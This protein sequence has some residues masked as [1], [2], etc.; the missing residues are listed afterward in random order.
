MLVW[1]PPRGRCPVFEVNDAVVHPAHGVGVIR[2]I[3]NMFISGRE[4]RY[5]VIEFPL[6]EIDRVLVPVDNADNVGLRAVVNEETIHEVL[7]ILTDTEGSYLRVV[8]DESF[9]KRHKEYVD[10]VQSG[11]IIEVAQVFKTLL[12]RS[13]DKDLGLK[14]KFLMERAEKM[15]LGEIAFARKI[16]LDNAREILISSKF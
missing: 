1:R 6:N 11:D 10:R 9:H 12:E 8:E 3:Q 13:R 2:E 4:S 15:L 7:R 14:E 5:Y 16:S